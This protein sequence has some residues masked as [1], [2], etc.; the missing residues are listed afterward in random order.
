[1]HKKHK[2]NL[3]I[4]LCF[5]CFFVARE[6][7]VAIFGPRNPSQFIAMSGF[8]KIRRLSISIVLLI[9]A[10]LFIEG[11]GAQ[12]ITQQPTQRPRRVAGSEQT[13]EAKKGTQS[14]GEVDEGDVI[15]TDTQLVSVPAVVTDSSGRPLSGLKPENFR[16][17]E[18]GQLQSIAN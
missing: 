5:L 6:C 4:L 8:T 13:T 2:M 9:V 15:R 11:T 17:V 14:A 3:A 1:K 16:I 12:Q 18:D 7:F 10:C